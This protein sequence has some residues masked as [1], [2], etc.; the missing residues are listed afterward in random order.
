MDVAVAGDGRRGRAAGHRQP[1]AARARQGRL[2]GK[3]RVPARGT[4]GCRPGDAS[5]RAGAAGR[6]G[7]QES[8]GADKDVAANAAA[9]DKAAPPS[10]IAEDARGGAEASSYRSRAKAAAKPKLEAKTPSASTSLAAG[11]KMKKSESDRGDVGRFA[12]PPPPKPVTGFKMDDDAP[13]AK[14]APP[15]DLDGVVSQPARAPGPAKAGG[16]ASSA[17]GVG[18][19]GAGIGGGGRAAE[20][21]VAKEHVA[22][23][24]QARL[25]EPAAAPAP[26]PPVA[27][28]PPP[29]RRRRG[30]SQR[31]RSIRRRGAQPPTKSRRPAPKKANPRR[32]ARP[33]PRPRSNAPTDC[34]PRGAGRRRSPPTASSCAA[35]QTTP[36]R[37]AGASALAIAEAALESR[38]TTEPASAAPAR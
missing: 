22:S 14:S 5:A 17:A 35:I 16:A 19:A 12:P 13:L 38:R 2:Q 26:P 9:A 15:A 8:Y 31:R 21:P 23:E 3:P 20:R 18:S 28:M 1:R 34:S 10:T 36:R 29:R 32:R 24:A 25:A 4:T 27:A 33:A 7:A 30:T 37:H 11:G 6:A